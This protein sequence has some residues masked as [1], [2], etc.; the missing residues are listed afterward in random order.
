MAGERPV[1]PGQGPRSLS[2]PRRAAFGIALLYAAFGSAWILL[3]DRLLPDFGASAEDIVWLGTLKGL[4]FI[5]VTSTL[6]YGVLRVTPRVEEDSRGLPSR[7][8]LLA[9]VFLLLAV[10]ILAVGYQ[11][12][13]EVGTNARERFHDALRAVVDTKAHR[14]GS[15]LDRQRGLVAAAA[16]LPALAEH[17]A[18]TLD[19]DG[20]ARRELRADLEHFVTAFGLEA[21]VLT[22]A[23]GNILLGAGTTADEGLV[24]A[25]VSAAAQH[26]T[27]FADANASGGERLHA[28]F[29]RRVE[30]TIGTPAIA[31]VVLVVQFDTGIAE[32][33][34]RWPLPFG[35]GQSAFARMGPDGELVL[36]PGF[37]APFSPR[38]R[39]EYP[40]LEPEGRGQYA[41]RSVAGI[42]EG[43]L[44]GG[45]PVLL[46]FAR[47]PGTPWVVIS[48][49]DASAIHAGIGGLLRNM[50]LV[51]LFAITAAGWLIL[52]LFRQQQAM[53]RSL[54]S[55]V[56]RERDALRAHFSY[57]SRFAND[58]VLLL[59][60]QG[61][62]L[63]CNERAI[64]TYGFSREELIGRNALELRPPGLVE[65]G[66]R[67]LS[68]V[69]LDGGLV[70]ETWHVR[71]D[72]STFPIEVSIRRFQ[73]DGDEF[74]QSVIR[75]ISERKSAED[76]LR[77]SEARYRAIFDHTAVGVVHIAPDGRFLLV[78]RRLAEMVGYSVAE[79]Q[80]MTVQQIT[81]P[82]DVSRQQHRLEALLEGR[83]DE[84]TLEKRYRHRDGSVVWVEVTMSAV[85]AEGRKLEHVV[86]VVADISARRQLESQL[87]RRN[88]LYRTLSEA[89]RAIARARDG[90]EL[91][92]EACRIVVT[93]PG[94]TIA[95]VSGGAPG[96][97]AG[98]VVASAGPEARALASELL[99]LQLNS[100]VFPAY[101]RMESH[102]GVAVVNDV[103]GGPLNAGM[104]LA[105]LRRGIRSYASFPLGDPDLP[106]AR[107]AVFSPEVG[108]F[109]GDTLDLLSDMARDLSKALERFAEREAR[110]RAEVRLREV[111]Q[112]MALLVECAPIP[113]F[114]LDAA[115]RVL[116]VWNPAAEQ[117]FGWRRDEVI[118]KRL[119][120]VPDEAGAQAQF[121][122]VRKRVL[123]GES[124]SALEVT[125][126]RRD[127]S[128][129][130]LSLS[131]SPVSGP[132]GT[133]SVLV[134]AEDIT[135]RYEA[136]EQ[137]ARAR[138]ELEQRVRDRTTELAAARDRAE[139]ADRIKTAFLANMSHEL[140]TPLNSIIGFSSLLLSG[141]PG[142][143]NEEQGKQLGIIRN[144]G[145]R[146]LAL[147][148]DVLDI[149]RLQAVDA[150]LPREP[151]PLRDM[152]LRVA[153][154][155]RPQAVGRGLKIHT[156]IEP[157]VALAEPRRL[158][159]VVTNL[160][161]N[162]VKYTD[163]GS[164]TVRCRRHEGRVEITVADTGIGIGPEELRRLFV[165]FAQ[166][167]RSDSGR[168]GTGLG[169]AISRRLVEAMGG[170]ISVESTPGEGSVFTVR[171]D[172]AEVD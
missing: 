43:F 147:I 97:E 100:G 142:G 40:L 48:G 89:N 72:G 21:L 34:R 133:P 65:A 62:I 130:H 166:L 159:Q 51:V 122:A 85:W 32:M 46:A 53:N 162:A 131:L 140:R 96:T 4:L 1:I 69:D 129:V 101:S 33:V 134:I 155:L 23:E 38:Q 10:A 119:P 50:A 86:G 92:W 77:L 41:R 161:S 123:A 87:R 172:A 121:D 116:G 154:A 75:D 137:M 37:Q 150:Q 54:V 55:N 165:P 28:A 135:L 29:A 99:E 22:D 151:T 84:F 120:I 16:S 91:L 47:V 9:V 145:E 115:G 167:R 64:L 136:A 141:A 76:E 42:Y 132:T 102:P 112:R 49:I 149:S 8:T 163:T 63:D 158:E 5:L 106:A 152:V 36:L 82:E 157:C 104:R 14:V 146:L 138:E 19:G 88:M 109:E 26:A 13:Q 68:M 74:I 3:S 113:V 81:V 57:L 59:D 80:G 93:Q 71:K 107:L 30:T 128:P 95:A 125:R 156:D 103:E 111:G 73:V 171:L 105:C 98:S 118:G 25:A 110:A 60:G 79:L 160:V 70:Y 44:P 94:L 27:G 45:A 143:V 169:L 144:A 153:D 126:Q 31:F 6:L 61:N 2:V 139:E 108:Y 124:V 66:R 170:S 148:E 18:A 164:V 24:A 117:A 56:V 7:G 78:N 52:A 90:E 168:D 11:F 67:Q 127:G 39:L 12:Q 58:I 114:D 20:G 15:W 35:N 83:E 17:G